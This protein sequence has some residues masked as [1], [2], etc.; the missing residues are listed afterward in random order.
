MSDPRAMDDITLGLV[1]RIAF[2]VALCAGY[3][4]LIAAGWLGDRS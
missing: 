1:L 4:A 2:V 3:G